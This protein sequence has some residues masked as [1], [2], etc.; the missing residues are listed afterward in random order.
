MAQEKKDFYKE[1]GKVREIYL[2]WLRAE[3]MG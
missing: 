2:S 3:A 1:P